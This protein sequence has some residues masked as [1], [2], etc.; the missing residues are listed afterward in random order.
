MS[1]INDKAF[2]FNFWDLNAMVVCEFVRSKDNIFPNSISGIGIPTRLIAVLWPH[3][4]RLSM[5]RN[6][7]C[8][9]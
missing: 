6:H 8:D 3:F 9:T 4:Q 2:D 7:F 1:V 5:I